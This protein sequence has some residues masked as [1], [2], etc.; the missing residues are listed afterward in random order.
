MNVFRGEVSV[1]GFPSYFPV[2]F[3]GE[4]LARLPPG[5]PPRRGP[6]PGAAREARLRRSRLPPPARV[7]LPRERGEQ[8]QHR[9]PARP[10]RRA[11]P[12]G[13]GGGRRS[14]AASPA[15]WRRRRSPASG[16]SRRPR[17]S[18]STPTRSRSSTS[19]P[20]GPSRGHLWL[21]D[22]NLDWGQDLVRLARELERRGGEAGDDGRVLRRR[23][24]D[25]PPPE[26]Q[27]LRRRDDAADARALRR[28]LVPPRG[29]PRADGLPRG[30]AA[31]GGLRAAP[32]RRWRSGGSRRGAWDTR[33]SFTAC[34]RRGLRR[35]EAVDHHARLQRAEDAPRDRRTGPRRRPRAHREGAR[36]RRR[37]LDGRHARHPP[38]AGRQGRHP[39]RL[40]AAQ[41]GEGGGGLG[42]AARLDRRPRRHPG[43]GPRVRPARDTRSS[44]GRS[45]RARPTSSTARA[46]S[47]TRA[48]TGSSTSGT[49]WGTGC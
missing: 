5:A 23:G 12:R 44:S 36:H 39:R 35:R 31:R 3:R 7:R 30:R 19:P 18:P 32:P 10:P 8:L 33:S 6:R 42:R 26:G 27:A 28:L 21:N 47:A 40:P 20:G 9:R 25:V 38:R 29:R 14:S 22:S 43:R 15:A 13:R 16:S 49:R 2:A 37:R 45:S 17:R 24:P 48:G 11:V 4:V 1:D 41:P 34:P 46:S